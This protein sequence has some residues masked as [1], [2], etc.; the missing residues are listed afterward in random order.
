MNTGIHVVHW[1]WL[2]KLA[3]AL[4]AKMTLLWHDILDL[5]L[6][7]ALIIAGVMFGLPLILLFFPELQ[8]QLPIGIGGNMALLSVGLMV[9]YPFAMRRRNTR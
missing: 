7:W 3:H 8:K 5:Y 4:R 9:L 1:P 6:Q 2:A